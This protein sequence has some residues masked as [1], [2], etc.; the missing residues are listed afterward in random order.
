MADEAAKD[1]EVGRHA[2][3]FNDTGA[4]ELYK[5]YV[6]AIVGRTNTRTGA[7]YRDD[8]TILA[9][10]LIN[11]PRCETWRVRRAPCLLPLHSLQADPQGTGPVPVCTHTGTTWVCRVVRAAL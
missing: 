3:F 8:P 4:R 5:E 7:L 1:Y 10:D 9:W 2:L 11:E 6:A